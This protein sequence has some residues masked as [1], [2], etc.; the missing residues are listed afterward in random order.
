MPARIGQLRDA[1]RR[2]ADWPATDLPVISA[3]LDLR[4]GSAGDNPQ[5]RSGQIVLRDRLREIESELE[6]NTPA[7]DSLVADIER[8]DDY[9]EN[10]ALP[11]VRC[12]ALFACHG[13]DE[14]VEVLHTSADLEDRVSAAGRPWLL[15]LARLSDQDEALLA[16]ADTNTLRIFALRS[17]ALEEIGLVDDDTYDYSQTS[18]GGWSQN[19]FQRHVEEHRQAFA[20]L[21]AQ[22]IEEV[23]QQEDARVVVLAGDEVALPLLTEALPQHLAERTRGSLRIDMRATAEEVE[24]EALA[25][26][27]TIQA[28][29]AEDAA[30]RLVG[31]S[32]SDGLGVAGLASTLEAL[33]L[34]QVDELLIDSSA[35]F[36]DESSEELIRL[37]ASTAARIRFCAGHGGLRK[38]G[39][40]GGLLRFRLEGP[41]SDAQSVDEAERAHVSSQGVG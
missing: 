4:P 19:R 32:R 25:F 30:D 18:A 1:L 34:G 23:A 27:E 17:G 12:L 31:A 24:E 14:R 29:D 21:A 6:A 20:Q 26:L 7:H 38:L 5:V 9:I 41:V 10:E 35:E 40:V 37:A 33:R 13:L 3:Y 28:A 11:D 36:D 22:A 2:L 8:I 15:P 16:L 39:G